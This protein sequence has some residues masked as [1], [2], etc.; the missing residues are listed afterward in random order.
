MPTTLIGA[1]FKLFYLI[2]VLKINDS[3][4]VIFE[5]LEKSYYNISYLL[6]LAMFVVKK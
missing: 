3:I 2:V 1:G 5:I 6:I 4:N